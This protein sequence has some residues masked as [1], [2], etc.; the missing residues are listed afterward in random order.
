L[1]A[2]GGE[3]RIRKEKKQK[4]EVIGFEQSERR[5]KIGIAKKRNIT[6]TKVFILNLPYGFY[7]IFILNPLFEHLSYTHWTCIRFLFSKV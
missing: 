7:W 6:A 2:G 5:R 4:G 3:R 1:E